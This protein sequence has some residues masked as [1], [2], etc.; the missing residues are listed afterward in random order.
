M[1]APEG[2]A[3]GAAVPEDWLELELEPEPMFGQWWELG[4]APERGA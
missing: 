4:S 3:T 2:G 1:L